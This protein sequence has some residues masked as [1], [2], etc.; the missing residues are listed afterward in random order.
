MTQKFANAARAYLASSISGSATTVTIDGGGSLFPAITSPEF[1][2]AVLQDNTG[3][4]VVLITAHTASSNSFTV[5]RAQEGT[6]ARSFA[7]GAVFG[8]RM[9]AADG[10]TFVAKVSGPGSATDS[11]LAAFDGTTGKLI[12]QA[13]TVT[14]AQGGTG[15]T[16]RQ[17]AM[18]ALAGA[19]TA[20]Q[21]LR[22]DGTDVV[23]SAI[24]AA[25]VPTLNQ[26]TT[27][28]AA[29]ATTAT[30][31][32]GGTVSATSI[33]YSTTLTGGT[34]VIN[35]GSGQI[36]KDASGNVGFGTSTPLRK[37]DIS[38]GGFAFTEVGG[39][40]RTIHWG[41]TTNIY[42]VTIIGSSS[43]GNG[44]LVFGTNTFGNAAIERMRIDSAGNVGI[45]TSSPSQKLEVSGVVRASGG[46]NPSNTGWANAAFRGQ[47]SFGGGLSLI[48]GSAGYGIWSQDSGGVLAIGQGST[49][50]ALT[51]RMRIDASGNVSVGNA[52]RAQLR[53]TGDIQAYRSGG[54]TGVIYLNSAETRYLY[55]DGT[56]YQLSG[57][58]VVA[59]NITAAGNTTGTA[60]GNLPLAGG[61]MTG[62]I[63]TRTTTGATPIVSGGG[64]DSLQ[65][66]GNGPNGAFMSFHRAGAYAVNL[67]IDT[68]NVVALGGWSDGGTS[69]WT[70][71]TSGN[72]VAR[73]NVTAYSDERLKKDWAPVAEDF[74]ER[75]AKV[76]HGTYT[77]TD[78]EERQMGVSAQTMRTFAPEVVLEDREGNL[79][80][81]YGNAALVAAVKLAE[82][83][84][85]LEARIAALEAKG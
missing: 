84:V 38:G 37:I 14:I 83:V 82:R 28:N 51:E 31:Q 45:G 75:L 11:A 71:D 74:V 18:D 41:D 32:S 72:F 62:Q 1:S 13:A 34:G 69:R 55:F 58:A 63:T 50:G 35:I 48:D 21:Y 27:G 12:K 6:T 22:G 24:Q 33:A 36:Y 60:A 54:T 78:S 3:I 47:G 8:L 30:N 39:A 56:S 42:P 10:D 15:Q 4:E 66:M 77:R 9:T 85:A 79:S 25:D 59:S 20:G 76:K 70:S 80:L 61:S 16:T 26:N 40:N 65:I 67:G 44:T 23:M 43:S 81:A 64:S 17:A 52:G 49:S 73:G 2:R 5:T 19:V 7:A 57:A 29:T 46:F 68:S 53:A